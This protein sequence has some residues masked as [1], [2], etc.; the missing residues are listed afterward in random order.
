MSR[1]DVN[2]PRTIGQNARAHMPTTTRQ[3]P[4]KTSPAIRSTFRLDTA[5]KTLGHHRGTRYG[6]VMIRTC[7]T[8]RCYGLVV[9]RRSSTPNV[10]L[11]SRGNRTRTSSTLR[12]TRS[13]WR[14]LPCGVGRRCGRNEAYVPGIFRSRN[15]GSIRAF[16]RMRTM[17]MASMSR[18]RVSATAHQNSGS[19]RAKYQSVHA[20]GEAT[21]RKRTEFIDCRSAFLVFI[22]GAQRICSSP[23][24]TATRGTHDLAGQ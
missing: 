21:A 20:A 16:R 15:E 9:R 5:I 14:R 11:L 7:E 2:A 13:G 24:R 17:L 1:A 23:A 6:P 12:R 4:R 19:P 10:L 3:R 22:A 8:S 18:K